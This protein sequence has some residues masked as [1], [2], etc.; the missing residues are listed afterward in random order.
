MDHHDQA[1]GSQESGTPSGLLTRVTGAHAF[2]LLIAINRGNGSG[3]ICNSNHST[4]GGVGVTEGCL[5]CSATITVSSF[6]CFVLDMKNIKT[7]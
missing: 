5:T 7:F 4:L 2:G 1:R 3:N 6:S